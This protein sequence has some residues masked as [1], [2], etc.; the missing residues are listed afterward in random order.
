M[1]RITA[2]EI[3]TVIGDYISP[4]SLLC[5]DSARNYKSFA[6]MKG[7][8][9]QA[10]NIRKGVYVKKRIYHIQHVNSYHKRLKKWMERFQ[11]VATKYLDNYLFWFR[12]L[13]HHKK[14]NAKDSR[15]LMLLDACKK[16]NYTTI[17]KLRSA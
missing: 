8:E 6:K 14:L 1:G 17:A 9:H 2:K 13:E 12:F 3:D 15:Q 10:I 11:G 7:I 16:A 5:S 4:S